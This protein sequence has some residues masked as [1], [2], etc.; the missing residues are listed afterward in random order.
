MHPLR[1]INRAV[2]RALPERLRWIVAPL[3]LALELPVV[4]ALGIAA[5]LGL[6]SLARLLG[7]PAPPQWATA[8]Q[9]GLGFTGTCV[10]LWFPVR[11]CV[12]DGG[13]HS[14]IYG[15]SATAVLAAILWGV[16]IAEMKVSPDSMIGPASSIAA[17][18]LGL[19]VVVAWMLGSVAIALGGTA[20][21]HDAQADA[22]AAASEGSRR[23]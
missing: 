8:A 20:P 5:T 4:V 16:G 15:V 3:A 6:G 21:A 10:L 12:R 7:L 2:T 19:F 9:W 17:Y 18:V 22:D 1:A 14:L 11:R 13:W 23:V